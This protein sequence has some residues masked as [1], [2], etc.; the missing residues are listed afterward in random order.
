MRLPSASTVLGGLVA[1]SVPATAAPLWTDI[2]NFPPL[3]IC[4]PPPVPKVV[5]I[6]F[7]TL[8]KV[9]KPF[10]PAFFNGFSNVS[11]FVPKNIKVVRIPETLVF[12][13][14]ALD[15]FLKI[16]PNATQLLVRK[17]VLN[18]TRTGYPYSAMGKVLLRDGA[19]FGW[20]SGTAVGPNLV[21][22]A[23]HCVPNT[24]DSSMEFIPA[25]DAD[26]PNPRP[27]GSAFVT[28]CLRVE[29]A[30][31]DGSDYAVCQL[32]G[33]IGNDSGYLGWVVPADDAYYTG[34]NPWSSVGYPY[35]FL[36][37]DVPTTED[38]VKVEAVQDGDNDGKIIMSQPYVE[39]G[40]S[41]GPLWSFGD[42]GV[43]RVAAVVSAIVGV[44]TRSD[45]LAQVTYHAGG[46]RMARFIQYGRSQWGS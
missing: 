23:N 30:L 45:I 26:D 38:E 41:G 3:P 36:N 13:D 44:S 29:P 20:C 39:Q 22:T 17:Q 25:F 35:T 12:R 43:P 7:A 10:M 32:D 21:L 18:Q 33:A 5:R 42:D 4:K 1:L 31:I 2:F 46:T 6:D 16:A 40:W 27:Y 9:T 19:K 15:V 28:Q 14:P 37:G 8:V 11:S 34:A 24:T